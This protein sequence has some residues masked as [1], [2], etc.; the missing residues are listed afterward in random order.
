[1]TWFDETARPAPD[2][3]PADPASTRR[4]RTSL[5]AALVGGGVALGLVVAGGVW[6]V[7]SYVEDVAADG[8][9]PPTFA[10]Q[11]PAVATGGCGAPAPAAEADPEATLVLEAHLQDARVEPRYAPGTHLEVAVGVAN[12][13]TDRARLRA[14]SDVV[15]V[16]VQDGVVV[17]APVAAELRDPDERRRDPYL[18]TVP[19]GIAASTTLEYPLV[20]C[21]GRPLARGAYTLQAVLVVTAPAGGGARELVAP[22]VPVTVD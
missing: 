7:G 5:V 9:P 19:A 16:A 21:D 2:P 11:S 13:G 20:G 8:P 1:M 14:A 6:A 3:G 10:R 17:G 18:L 15:V 4:R 22:P 12:V